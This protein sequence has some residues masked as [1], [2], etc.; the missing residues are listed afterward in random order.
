ML[1]NKDF[2]QSSDEWIYTIAHCELHLAFGHFDAEKMPGYEITEIDGNKHWKVSCNTRLWNMACD[3][4]ITKFLTDAKM[5]IR[6][7][8]R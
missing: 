4:Y 7:V 3:I 1:V 8:I 5:V 2:L 6:L